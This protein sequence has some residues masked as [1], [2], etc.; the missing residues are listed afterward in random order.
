MK[1]GLDFLLIS[2]I[3]FTCIILILLIRKNNKE[4]HDK[5]LT[6]IFVFILLVFLNYYAYLHQIR[7]LFYFT[8]VFADSIDV[9]IGPLFLIYIKGV[10]GKTSNSFRNNIIH[11]ILP[12]IYFFAI[13]IPDTINSFTNEIDFIYLDKIQNFLS[14]TI[15]YS[16]GYCVY[17]LWE[18][19]K[20][21]KL[22]KFNFSNL[23]NKDLSWVKYL[24]VGALFILG[25]DL[26][27][28]ILEFISID[29][30]NNDG[31]MTVI[32]IVFLIAYLGYYGVTQSKILLPDF[33]MQTNV[34]NSVSLI[35]EKAQGSEKYMYDAEEMKQLTAELRSLM[36]EHKPY[37]NEELTLALLADLLGVP[38]KKL[39]TLLN[40]NMS[41]SFY[42]YINGLRVTEVIEKM[43]LPKSEKYTILAMAFD[44]GFKSKSSFN[45]IFKNITQLSPSEYRKRLTSVVK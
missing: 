40:Q 6:G 28:N 2:G 27:S 9:F 43:S 38:D 3:L 17:S 42:N 37:L 31:F 33:L 44:C 23:E 5:V 22:V 41:S 26:V 10:I 29:I 13:S 12:F 35:N 7:T 11:F 21:Q 14:F 24:L 1:L 18:L 30:G 4:I 25:I 32:P 20:F 34:G 8:D 15:L 39:S 36:S 16:I 19:I 45:R